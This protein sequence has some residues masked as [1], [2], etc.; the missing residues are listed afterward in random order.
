MPIP[1]AP[2]TL[3]RRALRSRRLWL[4]ALLIAALLS[5]WFWGNSWLSLEALR[6]HQQDWGLWQ[7]SHPWLARA[8]FAAV[9][10]LVTALSLPGATVLTLAGGALFGWLEGTIVVL[11]SATLGATLA[12]LMAR[13]PDSFVLYDGFEP[14]GRM[15]I[16]Q[17]SHAG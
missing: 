16:A 5:A 10:V 3:L 1:P 9:Y 4:A 12:M 2:Q 8:A 11:L 14:S 15:H 6:Q 7:T 17:V 13:K